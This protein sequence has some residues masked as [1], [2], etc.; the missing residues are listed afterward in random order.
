M[1]ENYYIGRQHTEQ[2]YIC[3][4][5]KGRSANSTQLNMVPANKTL[6]RIFVLVSICDIFQL[7]SGLSSWE[8]LYQRMLCDIIM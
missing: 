3:V 5:I 2:K 6:N 1:F 8:H 7:A 4:Y